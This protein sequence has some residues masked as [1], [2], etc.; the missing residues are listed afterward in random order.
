MAEQLYTIPINEAFE[1]YDGC[2]LCRLRRKLETQSLQY[3]MGAA[4]ME[5]DIRIVT[6]KLGFCHQHYEA[7]LGMGNRLSLALMLESHLQY[8]QEQIP[9][10]E[11]KKP[12]RLGKFKKYDGPDPGEAMEALH[13]TCY[14]CARV[15]DFEKKYIS[16]VIYIYKKDP[17]FREKLQKQPYLCLHHAGALLSQGKQ[18]L[19]EADYLRLEQD[20]LT[21]VRQHLTTLRQNVTTF[22]RSFDHENAG[23]P[24]TQAAR[25]AV[26]GAVSFASG[27]LEKNSNS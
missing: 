2:A 5:P 12:G 17:T 18:D 3:I 15:A 1:A 8:L 27:D 13:S 7:M 26:E 21:L 16:N 4:M 23:K 11:D 22:C 9:G 19:S 14:V 20:I 6:N 25:Y 24:L 10:P